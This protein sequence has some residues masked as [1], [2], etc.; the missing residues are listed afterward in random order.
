[1][2][3]TNVHCFL[4]CNNSD[5]TTWFDDKDNN[6]LTN[7]AITYLSFCNNCDVT[8]GL[9]DEAAVVQNLRTDDLTSALGWSRQRVNCLPYLKKI[10]A[11]KLNLR[12]DINDADK[13]GEYE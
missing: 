6:I 13:W 11:F 3:C 1:M 7:F 5:V 9:W 10:D 2:I 12:T 8:A 4:F